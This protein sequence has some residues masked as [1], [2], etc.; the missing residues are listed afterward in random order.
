ELTLDSSLL[1]LGIGAFAG[2]AA[3]FIG[4]GGGVIMV[5]VLLELFRAW[6]LP[7]EVL[8]QAA[9]GT[10]LAVATLSVGSSALRHSRQGTVLWRVVPFLAPASMLG[11]WL[12]VMLARHLP[13]GGLQR[14]L[15]VVLVFVALRMWFEKQGVERPLRA[16]R[17]W[18]W[19]LLGFGTGLFA[20]LT[21]LAGGLVLIP[22]MALVA[23]VS[24]RN[25]AGTS[26]G[27]VTFT[28]LAAAVGYL[29]HAPAVPLPSGF[30]GHVQP[31]V[32]LCLA[33]ASVPA[34]QLG[35]W[36]NKKAD[37]RVYRRV[38]GLLL[39]GVVIRLFL[40]A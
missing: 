12:A 31:A 13:G 4:I 6:E 19:A 27:V 26:S 15:A 17:W 29:T 36:L 14:F 30:I 3:G 11:G 21:G 28:A 10:S 20:G 5:P 2:L 38:F 25:L 23:H 18:S 32:A 33:L 34:A 40:T 35:A 1:L 9:M 8:V 22:A 24:T 37:S 16:L 39:I 7:P